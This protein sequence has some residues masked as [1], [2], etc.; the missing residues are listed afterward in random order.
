MW[1]WLLASSLL[2][3]VNSE[4]VIIGPVP[5]GGQSPTLSFCQQRFYEEE[6]GLLLCNWAVNFRYACFV[7]A[8]IDKALQAGSKISEPEV[9]GVCDDGE[10][11]IKLL[12]Y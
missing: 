9:V 3:P 7:A 4:T 12:H 11:V 1:Q 2:M 6:E 5:G 8:P 10:P